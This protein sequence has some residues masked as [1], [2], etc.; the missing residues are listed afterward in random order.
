MAKHHQ[1][2]GKL[3]KRLVELTPLKCLSLGIEVEVGKVLYSWASARKVEPQQTLVLR[4]A[5]ESQPETCQF[6]VLEVT[7][8]V[9]GRNDKAHH[10]QE[11]YTDNEVPG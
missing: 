4:E 5:L 11:W 10:E 8:H 9:G 3:S 6:M 2:R 7:P 1:T